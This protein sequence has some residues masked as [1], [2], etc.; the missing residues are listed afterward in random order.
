MSVNTPI[1]N[2]TIFH[3]LHSGSPRYWIIVPREEKTHLEDCVQQHF[4][5]V[6]GQDNCSQWIHHGSI[7]ISPTLLSEWGIKFYTVTQEIHQL[8]IVFPGS[9]TWGYSS[10][11]SILE[12]KFHAG[13]N[14]SLENYRPCDMDIQACISSPYSKGMLVD[15][16]SDARQVPSVGTGKRRASTA[17]ASPRLSQLSKT[18]ATSAPSINPSTEPEE[19]SIVVDPRSVPDGIHNTQYLQESTSFDMSDDDSHTDVHEARYGEILKLQQENVIL[20]RNTIEAQ[21]ERDTAVVRKNEY[22]NRLLE[23][24][25]FIKSLE[26]QLVEA[27]RESWL[28]VE[29]FARERYSSH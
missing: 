17:L 20:R 11:F 26:L 3:F 9:Y 2:L 18:S 12:S 19:N 10:G 13:N 4:Q 6:I 29:R 7:W 22:K 1:F 5:S 8:F 21:V 24:E 25:A 15:F 27:K 23:R 28:E 14:W 16:I